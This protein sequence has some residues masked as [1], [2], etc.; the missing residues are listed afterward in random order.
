MKRFLFS[1]ILSSLCLLLSFLPVRA[2]LAETSSP[3]R[4][5]SQSTL[6]DKSF[7]PDDMAHM[8]VIPEK[9]NVAVSIRLDEG[10][11]RIAVIIFERLIKNLDMGEFV[12]IFGCIDPAVIKKLIVQ[13]FSSTLSNVASIEFFSIFSNGRPPSES[14]IFVLVNFTGERKASEYFAEKSVLAQIFAAGTSDAGNVVIMEK[15][16]GCLKVLCPIIKNSKTGSNIRIFLHKNSIGAA[17]A[18]AGCALKPDDVAALAAEAAANPA[19]SILSDKYFIS[20]FRKLSAENN[21]RIYADIAGVEGAFN[22]GSTSGVELRAAKYFRSAAAGIKISADCTSLKSELSLALRERK[23]LGTDEARIVSIALPLIS[24]DTA[25]TSGAAAASSC[26]PAVLS[27]F[28]PG[29]LPSSTA[30]LLDFRLNFS[31]DFLSIPEVFAFRGFLL[32]AGL[33]FKEDFLSWM[34]GDFFFA[35][36]NLSCT[37]ESM[38]GKKPYPVPDLCVGL[39]CSDPE[40][41]DALIEKIFDLFNDGTGA[42][43]LKSIKAGDAS[44]KTCRIDSPQFTGLE[45]TFGFSRGYYFAASNSAY[46]NRIAASKALATSFDSSAFIKKGGYFDKNAFFSF[47]LDIAGITETLR[48]AAAAEPSLNCLFAKKVVESLAISSSFSDGRLY[49]RMD[50]FSDPAAVKRIV[51]GKSPKAFGDD[52][53]GPEIPDTAELKIK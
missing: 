17:F 4:S 43:T 6:Q 16:S 15:N 48:R 20:Q 49:C 45:P 41:A 21:V 22:I 37:A 33:D 18:P 1:V 34:R 28:A 30:A 3:K 36:E 26:A 32:A 10:H 13:V 35:C 38:D 29:V 42:V 7:P 46:F 23:E 31:D 11:R 51:Y 2:E 52:G 44:V 24:N 40:K 27:S 8:R 47:Y 53:G 19:R 25:E 39:N 14:P 50:L 12:G 5:E 9:T